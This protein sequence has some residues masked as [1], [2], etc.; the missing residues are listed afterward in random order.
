MWLHEQGYTYHGDAPLTGLTR[1]EYDK[2][3]LGHLVRQ[4]QKEQAAERARAG[5]SSDQYQR[6]R[7]RLEQARQN[8]ADHGSVAPNSGR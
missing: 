6:K 1:F 2:L 5:D 7:G 3:Q 4:E 8:F